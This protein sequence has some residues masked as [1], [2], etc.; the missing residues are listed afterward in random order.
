MLRSR[1]ALAF[2]LLSFAVALPLTAAAQEADPDRCRAKKADAAARYFS[3]AY[4]CIVTAE[5]KLED[6]TPCLDKAEAKLAS[7]IDRLDTAR[8]ACAATIDAATLAAQIDANVEGVLRGVAKRVFR[9][10]TIGGAVFGGLAGAD[11]QCQQ[12]ADAAA[13]GGRF[14][15]MLSDSTTDMR[16]RIGPAPGGFVRIDDV[17][18]ATGR[19][20][21]FDGD[22][23][24]AIQVDEN[25]T[26][27]GAAEVWTGSTPSGQ[28]DA[29]GACSDWSSTSGITSVGG[30]NQI[31]SDW[32]SV[33]LQFCDRTNVALYC[34]EQ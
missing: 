11:A 2:V 5:K 32:I 7:T 30:V 25:G 1:P 13:L 14:I 23:L 20:D 15:A 10:S 19:L 33:Y 12:L 24:A 22:L 34:V 8:K 16:D 21:L 18:V 17:Q 27:P 31:D 9:T 3:A 26:T 4:K 6:P 28:R 29:T